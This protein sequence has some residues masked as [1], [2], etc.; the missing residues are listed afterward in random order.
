MN[1]MVTRLFDGGRVMP[2]HVRNAGTLRGT[3]AI[4]QEDD[5]I[6]HRTTLV[7]R[8][9]PK[10]QIGSRVREATLPAAQ[11]AAGLLQQSQHRLP[12]V[13]HPLAPT[14]CGTQ[15]A[16]QGAKSAWLLDGW[17]LWP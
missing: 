15:A 17:A 4:K 6:R 9:S 2:H 14:L 8:F 5:R 12:G 1:Y 11:S 10:H 16:S 7:A 13:R 3:L